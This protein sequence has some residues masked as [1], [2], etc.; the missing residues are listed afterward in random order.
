MKIALAKPVTISRFNAATKQEHAIT[1]EE[2]NVREDATIAD[3]IAAGDAPNQQ[4]AIFHLLAILAD[5]PRHVI[6][7][8][9]LR[10][11]VAHQAQFEALMM[12]NG[13]APGSGASSGSS[14]AS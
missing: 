10:W 3:L 11:G 4:A 13:E 9:P 2:I 8:Q 6:T 5:V 7:S 1:Y 14:S 12:G